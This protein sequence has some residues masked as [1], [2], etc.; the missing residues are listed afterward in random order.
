[1]EYG[2]LS[3]FV[4][5]DEEKLKIVIIF[6]HVSL[7]LLESHVDPINESHIAIL[8]LETR[9]IYTWKLLVGNSNG[10]IKVIDTTDRSQT[11]GPGCGDGD[12]DDKNDYYGAVFEQT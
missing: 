3:R 7:I 6:P 8:G 10:Q 5:V 2:S 1:L 9:T 12:L 4:E 11:I